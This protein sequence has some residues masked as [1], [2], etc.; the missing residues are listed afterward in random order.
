M[1][2]KY[3]TFLT[4]CFYCFSFIIFVRTKDIFFCLLTLLLLLYEIHYYKCEVQDES[5][6]EKPDSLRRPFLRLRA[7][8]GKQALWRV[9]QGDVEQQETASQGDAPGVSHGVMLL[10]CV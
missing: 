2:I 8:E 10:G 9:P 1:T 5:N 4:T 6:E 7:L 3:H